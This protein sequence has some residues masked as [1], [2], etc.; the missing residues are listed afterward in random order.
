MKR[1]MWHIHSCQSLLLNEKMFSFLVGFEPSYHMFEALK[2]SYH[3][4]NHYVAWQ[5]ATLFVFPTSTS[6]K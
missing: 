1:G 2:L 4:T 5:N 6:Q 3:G